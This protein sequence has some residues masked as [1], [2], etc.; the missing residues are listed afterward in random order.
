VAMMEA[1]EETARAVLGLLED[2]GPRDGAVPARA[3]RPR[4]APRR[5]VPARPGP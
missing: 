2:A 5:A 4:R 3:G 1:P